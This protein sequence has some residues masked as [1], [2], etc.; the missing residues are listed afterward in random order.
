VNRSLASG[1]E[2]VV[3][4]VVVTMLE[5]TAGTLVVVIK[6]AVG[7]IKTP[8]AVKSMLETYSRLSFFLTVARVPDQ[9]AG[10]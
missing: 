1:L 2:T 9:L 3:A 8:P 10:S 4:I 6:V 7:P 5:D